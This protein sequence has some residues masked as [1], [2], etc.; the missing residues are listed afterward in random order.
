MPTLLDSESLD[1]SWF[2]HVD[3]E[4]EYK[5]TKKL[6]EGSFGLVRVG[7]PR[8]GDKHQPDVAVKSVRSDK[9]TEEGDAKALRQECDLLKQYGEHPSIVSLHSVYH[10]PGSKHLDMIMDLV[11]GGMLFDAIVESPAEHLTERFAA[12]VM[13][14]CCDAL[15]FLHKSGVAH[16]DIKPE[17]IMVL[18]HTSSG[19][20]KGFAWDSP[21]VQ[22]CDFGFAVLSSDPAHLMK[23]AC[24]TPEYV[25]PEVLGQTGYDVKCDVWS[26]GVVLYVMLCGYTPFY[27]ADV[28]KL[29]RL[30]AKGNLDMPPDEW[31]QVSDDAKDLVKA[32]LTVDPT[33][34][35]SA[36]EVLAHPWIVKNQL[37]HT[38]GGHPHALLH[39]NLGTRL[40]EHLSRSKGQRKAGA[41]ADAVLSTAGEHDA[42]H[43]SGNG[44]HAAV[45]SAMLAAVMGAAGVEHTAHLQ[46][47]ADALILADTKAT[48]TAYRVK[49]LFG[50]A[51]NATCAE[52]DDALESGPPRQV[53][54]VPKF[55]VLVC[56]HCAAAYRAMAAELAATQSEGGWSAPMSL[57]A[58]EWP[59]ETA[60]AMLAGG[61][62]ASNAVLEGL[63]MA[64]ELKPSAQ[65]SE[66]YIA[67]WVREKYDERRF[68]SDCTTQLG[69]VV[70]ALH[71]TVMNATDLKRM[72][73]E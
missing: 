56:A 9:L 65:S 11:S 62:T 33:M 48:S 72:D 17:N 67:E 6:G 13:A 51:G 8:H 10:K 45:T 21:M 63:P 38:D 69:A 23:Q 25:A 16:R 1:A 64:A 40:A 46:A 3:V 24:G 22:L 70:G 2:K 43:D 30:V 39:G 55:G 59:K 5:L 31:G 47:T 44:S 14:H 29:F 34:R 71:V 49:V 42:L 61:N 12:R 68:A 41:A 28:N 60:A 27:D 36:Q 53:Y 54:A 32:M 66:G 37:E 19:D 58:D 4:S 50:I 35:P 7:H 15:A 73:C 20:S 52:C 26:M 18:Q 57:V